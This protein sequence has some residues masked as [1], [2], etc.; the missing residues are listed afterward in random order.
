MSTCRHVDE[1]EQTDWP[2]FISYVFSTCRQ[3]NYS[4][5]TVSGVDMLASSSACPL[6]L[7]LQILWVDCE[8]YLTTCKNRHNFHLNLN[9]NKYRAWRFLF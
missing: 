7:N 1:G 9:L 4:D 5:R 8:G 3:M 2:W 6:G